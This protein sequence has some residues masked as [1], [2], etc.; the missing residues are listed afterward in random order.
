[1]HVDEN[2]LVR[3]VHCNN[4]SIVSRP[5]VKKLWSRV[6]FAMSYIDLWLRIRRA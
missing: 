2:T 4:A 1:V 5:L 3:R 6:I